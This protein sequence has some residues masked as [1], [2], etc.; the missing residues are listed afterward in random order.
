M[1]DYEAADAEKTNSINIVNFSDQ[2]EIDTIY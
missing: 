2:L 1:E